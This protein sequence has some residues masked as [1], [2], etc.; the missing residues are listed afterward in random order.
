MV[1]TKEVN[2]SL[3]LAI[4]YAIWDIRKSTEEEMRE[5]SA[6][7]PYCRCSRTARGRIATQRRDRAEAASA[8]DG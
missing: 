1:N 7:F 4:P 6:G 3:G 5:S 8:P 2:A